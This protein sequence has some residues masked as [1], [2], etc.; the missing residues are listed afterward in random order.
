MIYRT[1]LVNIL[2][3]QFIQKN[4][5]EPSK[6]DFEMFFDWYVKENR[7]DVIHQRFPMN[8]DF[9]LGVTVRS[10][11]T[12]AIFI[13]KTSS[14]NRSNFSKCHEL[15]H[16]IFDMNKALPT[17]TFYNV[18]N[19]TS[20]YTEDELKKE[21]LANVGAGAMMLPDIKVLE[22]LHNDKSFLRVADECKMSRAAL[23]R[24]MIDFCVTKCEM[25][26]K[27]AIILVR[28]FQDTKDKY[29]INQRLSGWGETKEKQIILDFEN[30]I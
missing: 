22:Y 19:N 16:C 27:N 18:E 17:Q 30:S 25:S 3:N 29:F 20:F 14:K 9:M 7:I 24:R 12:T 6:Y 21:H 11:Y 10:Q 23:Y 4:E 28:R 8:E 1:S 15:N 2:V 26:E 13:N 5:I